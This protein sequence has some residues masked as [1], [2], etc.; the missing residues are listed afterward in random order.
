MS[1]GRCSDCRYWIQFPKDFQ[2]GKCRRHAP[3]PE[4]AG[5][6][7][8]DIMTRWPLTYEHNWCGEYIAKSS[9]QTSGCEVSWQR[10]SEES[11]G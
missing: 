5:P 10:P 9:A 3:Q 7:K 1:N 6:G 2:I 8:S 11:G 4:H